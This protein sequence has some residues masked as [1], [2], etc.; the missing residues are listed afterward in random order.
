MSNSREEPSIDNEAPP[1]S[2]AELTSRFGLLFA[3]NIF[4]AKL[5]EYGLLTKEEK[6]QW[7]QTSVELADLAV[8][9]IPRIIS[10]ELESIGLEQDPKEDRV[11]YITLFEGAHRVPIGI[12]PQLRDMLSGM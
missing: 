7:G 10:G 9:T 11:V 4:F 8:V 1:L 3:D 12:N 2:E 6:H 5:R